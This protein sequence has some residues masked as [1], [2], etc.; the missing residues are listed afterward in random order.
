MER[1]DVILVGTGKRARAWHEVLTRSPRTRPVAVVSRSGANPFDLPAFTELQQ[2][3]ASH[4]DARVAVALPPRAGLAAAIALAEEG[5]ASLVEAPLYGALAEAEFG[6]AGRAVQVAHGW[7]T[8]AGVGWISKLMGRHPVTSAEIDVRGLPEDAEGDLLDAVVH[9]VALLRRL[10]PSAAL[11]SAAMAGEN[12][13]EADWRCAGTRVRLRVRPRGD[14]GAVR[15]QG[16]GFS[17]AWSWSRTEETWSVVRPGVEGTLSRRQPIV[18]A[19]VRAIVQLVDPARVGGDDLFSARETSRVVRRIEASLFRR[20]PIGRRSLEASAA[21][22]AAHPEDLGGRLGLQGPLPEASKASPLDLVLPP[23]PLELWPFRAGIKPVAFLTMRPEE[24]PAVRA[25]FGDAFIER[26][27]RLVHVGAQDRWTDRRDVGEPRVELYISRDP[28]LARRAVQLQAEADPTASLEQM[29]ELMGY[30]PCCVKAFA[31][32]SDRSNN[33][34][35]RY[36]TWARTPPGGRW[37]WELN[38]L[39]WMPIAFYPCSYRCE[40]ALTYARGALS[41]MDRAHPGTRDRLRAAL[42]RP[43]LYFDH[44]CQVLFDGEVSSDGVTFRDVNVTP[45]APTHF[46]RFAGALRDIGR[47]EFA[48]AALRVFL[49]DRSSSTIA[50]TDPGLGFLAPF[51]E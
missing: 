36:A 32:Q 12:L 5:R 41:E 1:I 30:P 35:N 15:L 48:D 26:R 17:A 38:N 20:W 4:P 51:G 37:P 28:A 2:A 7:T 34:A 43:V 45:G 47:V 40:R 18:P 33:T 11:E 50:R 22:I 6:E 9:A 19:E 44:D 8:L 42:A 16:D 14:G 29:G 27:E 46:S 25:V 21:A 13:L 49:R 3:L 23:E 39:F 31:G 24:E 10:F